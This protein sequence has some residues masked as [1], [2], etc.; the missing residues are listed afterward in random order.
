MKS[1]KLYLLCMFMIAILTGCDRLGGNTAAVIDLTAISKA[2]GQDEVVKSQMEKATIE[3]NAQL[4]EAAAQLEKQLADKKE[5]YGESATQEQNK[6]LQKFA[7]SA[8][9]QLKQNQAMAQ[10]QA[11]QYQ[12]GLLLTWRDQIQ[13]VVE[14]VARKHNAKVVLVSNP[15]LMWFDESVD[16]T[17]E[18]IA[19]LRARPAESVAPSSSSP[20]DGAEKTEVG[21][22]EPVKDES[23]ASVK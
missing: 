2:T 17:G 21:T 14:E 8:G 18:V 13:P 5:E 16:I 15:A 1:I 9:Q 6:E 22:G 11:Q 3:L 7:L 12:R 23:D 10:Q 19:A 20:S 4:S